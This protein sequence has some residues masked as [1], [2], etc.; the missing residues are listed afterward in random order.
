LRFENNRKDMIVK[1][2]AINLKRAIGE[3]LARS[4]RDPTQNTTKDLTR[5]EIYMGRFKEMPG[6]DV[7]RPQVGDNSNI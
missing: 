5:E 3:N 2:F 4:L 1:S 7:M 6:N